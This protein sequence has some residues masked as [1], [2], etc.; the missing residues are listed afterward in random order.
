MV[1]ITPLSRRGAGVRLYF[2]FFIVIFK[3]NSLLFYFRFLRNQIATHKA[4]INAVESPP[5][6]A[7]KV[8]G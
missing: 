7:N 4:T 5:K 2:E 3:I 6:I 8:A 1:C